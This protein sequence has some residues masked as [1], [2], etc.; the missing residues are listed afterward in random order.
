VIAKTDVECYRLDKESFEEIMLER[1]AIADEIAQILV[2]RRAQLDSA[3]QN[4]D[5]ESLDKEIHHQHNE[6]LLTVKR[7]FGL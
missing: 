3:M 1:P 4:L 7:F 5:D 6:V 2:E